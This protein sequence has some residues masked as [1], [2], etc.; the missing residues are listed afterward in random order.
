MHEGTLIDYRLRLF[1]VP[2][3]WRTLIERW[4]PP[5]GFVDRQ[6]RGPYALWRHR[7][8]F[9][10]VPRGTLMTD[11]VDYAL[12]LKKIPEQ[13]IGFLTGRRI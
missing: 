11:I 4:E 13:V 6:L 9:R 12:P 1:G 8:E 10:E 7:H 3:G 5:H 2:F